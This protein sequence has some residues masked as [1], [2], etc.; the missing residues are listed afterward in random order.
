MLSAA[1]ACLDPDQAR[2]VGPE[3]GSPKF[4][5]LA[6]HSRVKAGRSML[7]EGL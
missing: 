5:P 7:F 3:A 6:W 1:L 4:L 2:E